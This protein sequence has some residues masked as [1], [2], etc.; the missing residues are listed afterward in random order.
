MHCLQPYRA[1]RWVVISPQ[2]ALVQRGQSGLSWQRV[3]SYSKAEV[4]K[5]E[6]QSGIGDT[7][8]Y[9][10]YLQLFVC[11]M[12]L[13]AVVLSVNEAPG[14]PCVLQVKCFEVRAQFVLNRLPELVLSSLC[15]NLCLSSCAFWT[16]CHDLP[17]IL[18]VGHASTVGITKEINSYDY[19]GQKQ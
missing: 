9:L 8:P 2:A 14:C 11:L 19:S 3:P 18:A 5:W 16:S 17:S 12:C 1:H 6:F 7:F 13:W 15:L 10:W 4:Q